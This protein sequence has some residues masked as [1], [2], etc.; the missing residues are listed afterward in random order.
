MVGRR[1]GRGT[2]S[3]CDI[4]KGTLS[5]LNVIARPLFFEKLHQ[6]KAVQ[7]GLVSFLGSLP[8][9]ADCSKRIVKRAKSEVGASG[10]QEV[11]NGAQC[12]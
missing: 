3:L 12:R 6:A 10:L 5:G 2:S 4:T 11:K 9:G 1:P 8:E 7:G